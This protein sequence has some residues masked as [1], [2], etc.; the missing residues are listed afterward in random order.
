MSLLMVVLLALDLGAVRQE[1]NPERRSDLALENA[2]NA[3]TECGQAYKEG[4]LEKTK[5]EASEVEQSVTLAY[6]SLH[7]AGKDPRRNPKFFK[8]A[9]LATRQLVRRLD[10]LIE[11]MS[12][13]DRAALL[14]VR[15]R[16]SDIH[17]QLLSD[18]MKKK[19]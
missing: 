9:E 2:G 14:T 1:P 16:V 18:I 4:D 12:V 7:E 5:A 17:D 6:D 15:D 11:S 10:G 8:R 13:A 19:N 3:L